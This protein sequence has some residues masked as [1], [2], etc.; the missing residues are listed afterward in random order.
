MAD[1]SK[2][3]GLLV[4]ICCINTVLVFYTTS[5]LSN[6]YN[7]RLMSYSNAI[8]EWKKGFTFRIRKSM[9]RTSND[10][11]RCHNMQTG[12]APNLFRKRQVSTATPLSEQRGMR[13]RRMALAYHRSPSNVTLYQL[14]GYFQTISALPTKKCGRSR[15]IPYGSLDGSPEPHKG[16]R[17]YPSALGST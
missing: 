8:R 5:W 12:M 16:I 14:T 11:I 6:G 3:H 17:H 9:R 7:A 1:T 10:S 2:Y 13:T 15:N 4:G